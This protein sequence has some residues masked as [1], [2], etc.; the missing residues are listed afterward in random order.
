MR[1]KK[2]RERIAVVHPSEGMLA[3]WSYEGGL[4]ALQRLVFLFDAIACP[5]RLSDCDGPENTC[6]PWNLLYDDVV[7][8]RDNG[9]FIDLGDDDTF[10]HHAKRELQKSKTKLT[11]FEISPWWELYGLVNDKVDDML[12]KAEA[13]RQ[14]VQGEWLE[15]VTQ[16][17]RLTGYNAIPIFENK[18]ML[19][20]AV[21]R[22]KSGVCR[23]VLDYLPVPDQGGTP[24][25]DIL[26]YKNDPDT[27]KEF[28]ALW[29][30]IRKVGRSYDGSTESAED[31]REEISELVYQRERR[32]RRDWRK[33]S[34]LAVAA[35]VPTAIISLIPEL[36]GEVRLLLSSGG[37]LTLGLALAEM[38][39]PDRE[40]DALG[41]V[42]RT[43]DSFRS[44]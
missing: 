13:R 21:R 26:A 38:N 19:A 17:A 44:S 2:A 24:W 25:A 27:R 36:V 34:R 8:L 30:W 22:G 37:A 35:L 3:K 10:Q 43:N 39:D 23:V 6:P 18:D 14:R 5:L 7:W 40:R 12:R 32:I 15:L 28:D 16:A 41:Y 20:A 11:L 4:V 9:I 1:P 33:I 42:V 29:S 31:L